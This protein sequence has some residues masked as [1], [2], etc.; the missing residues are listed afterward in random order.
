MVMVLSWER[1]VPG[2][3]SLLRKRCYQMAFGAGT[4]ISS[5]AL[6]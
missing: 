1:R 2:F 6:L 4:R 5:P 3:Q